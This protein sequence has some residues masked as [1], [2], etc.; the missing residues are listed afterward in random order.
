MSILSRVSILITAATTTL[1]TEVHRELNMA[2]KP[3][4]GKAGPETH[5]PRTAVSA[6][7]GRIPG[8]PIN[9]PVR[10]DSTIRPASTD[11]DTVAEGAGLS[12]GS[13][14]SL[15]RALDEASDRDTDSAEFSVLRPSASE[16]GADRR[17]PCSQHSEASSSQQVVQQ[18][19]A[20]EH[21]AEAGLRSPLPGW[22]EANDTLQETWDG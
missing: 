21:G 7:R 12:Q 22:S 6:P 4:P 10:R 20:D 15:D 2:R 8:T 11:L 17:F 1:P 13:P 5:P 14:D 16:D 19:T 3:L 9:L 18:V